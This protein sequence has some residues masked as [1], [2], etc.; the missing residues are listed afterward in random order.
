MKKYRNSFTLIE[1]VFVIVVVGILAAISIPRFERD[2]LY[3]AADQV[4]QN[5]RYTQQLAM[6]DDK[7]NANDP[8]WIKKLWTIDFSSANVGDGNEWKHSIYADVSTDGNL[9][10]PN[11]AAR[12]PSNPNMYMSAGWAG[13]SDK[14][15]R[16]INS[17]M[18]LGKKY[19]ITNITVGNLGQDCS[20]GRNSAISFDNLGR[21]YRRV[22]VTGGGS[23]NPGDRVLRT[24]CTITLTSK[25][26]SIPITIQP[27][28]GYVKIENINKI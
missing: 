28:T 1:L 2:N 12:H 21:P 15:K 27:E 16:N 23:K 18:N 5:I 24:I 26:K 11:E 3:E 7:F 8:L 19:N 20:T 17:R 22:A 10:S 14:D 9:N 4:A 25:D 13:I 6:N